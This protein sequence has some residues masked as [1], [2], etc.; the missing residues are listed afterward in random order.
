MKQK[1]NTK[2]L[3][4]GIRLKEIKLESMIINGKQRFNFALNVYLPAQWFIK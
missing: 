2:K 4:G 3:K 1:K